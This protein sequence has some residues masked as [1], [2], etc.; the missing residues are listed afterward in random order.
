LPEGGAGAFEAVLV[1]CPDRLARKYAYQVL[2][3]E[4]L[5]RFDVQVI[6]L[7]DPPSEDPHARVFV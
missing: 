6:F 7:E 5:E 4:E 1:L 2:I 3:I